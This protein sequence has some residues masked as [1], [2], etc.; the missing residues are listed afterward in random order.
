MNL[1]LISDTKQNDRIQTFKYQC[2]K[3]QLHLTNVDVFFTKERK[4]MNHKGFGIYFHD[5]WIFGTQIL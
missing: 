1:T 5:S 4:R 3:V 2:D